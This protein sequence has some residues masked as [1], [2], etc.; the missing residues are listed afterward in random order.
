[1]AGPREWL[2]SLLAN[3]NGDIV[4]D[5]TPDSAGLNLQVEEAEF[6]E[7]RAG[8]G[9]ELALM[10]LA[11]LDQL[12]QEDLAEG[13]FCG[14]LVP[15]QSAVRLERDLA[16]ILKF[17][18]PFTG[19]FSASVTGNTRQTAFKVKLTP[20]L[21]SGERIEHYSLKG[22]ILSFSTTERFLLNPGQ[23]AAL[24]AV[25]SH[26]V[27]SSELSVEET[28]LRLVHT[29]QVARE[30]GFEAD[31]SHFDDLTIHVPPKIGLTV[32]EQDDGSLVLSPNLN[33]G[34]APEKVARGMG[35]ALTGGKSGS[36]RVDNE[37]ILLDEAAISSVKHVIERSHVP[38][39]LAKDFLE[40]PTMY[41]DSAL[42][43]LD[44][45]FSKRVKG[46]GVYTFC[47]FGSDDQKSMDWF[48]PV[49]TQN[50]EEALVE[51]L[52]SP[53][54]KKRLRQAIER[55][56]EQGAGEVV[57]EGVTLPLTDD[58]DV[59]EFVKN[60][61]IREH[62]H[63]VEGQSEFPEGLPTPDVVEAPVV[64][65]SK[66]VVVLN[67]LEGE[68]SI[69]L[70]GST[71]FQ[72]NLEN[73]A[74]SPFP[75]QEEGV[76]WI[77]SL[78][79]SSG[80]TGGLLADDM[81]LGKTYMTLVA[82]QQWML[83]QSDDEERKPSLIVAPLAL[84]EN[85]EEEVA[86]TFKTSPFKDIV[87]L[88]AG[89]DLPRYRVAG[90]GKET[91]QNVDDDTV[92]AKEE[93]RYSL[94]IGDNYKK[95]RLD[96]PARLVITTYQTLASYQFSLCRVDWNFVVFDEAQN[97]KNLNTL[98]TRAAKGLKADFKLLATGTPVENSLSDFWCLMD[99]AQPGLLGEWKDFNQQ[100]IRPIAIAEET[101]LSVVRAEIGRTLRETVGSLMLRRL[102]EETLKGLPK[103]TVYS[104]RDNQEFER[105]HFDPKLATMLSGRQLGVYDS[106]V[107]FVREN[108]DQGPAVILQG[109][110][111][112][113]AVSIHP[114]ARNTSAPDPAK[115]G[116]SSV[117][118]GVVECL[119][120]EV[121]GRD[122]KVIVF[123]INKLVQ[124]RLKLWLESTFGISVDIVNGETK[125]TAKDKRVNTRK[126]IVDSFQSAPGFGVLIMSPIAAGVGLTITGANNVI[127]LERHWNP[128]K[129]AQ[130]TDRVYRIGATKDVNV[131][132]P[133][134]HHPEFDSFEVTL[135]RLL[136]RKTDLKDAVV[137]TEDVNAAD[138][139]AGFQPA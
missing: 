118:I 91:K 1:M 53:E 22:P 93:I 25:A 21:A 67:E 55:A 15:S 94:K 85:W 119:V 9:S 86:L 101:E 44:D 126:R 128:A 115:W 46:A 10:Q 83:N 76:K 2:R 26:S 40:S 23:L 41:L 127:H 120:S 5:L 116:D 108:L 11:F 62:P 64:G 63:E 4:F 69:D 95:D 98:Q 49:D 56:Q 117:K 50:V 113:R 104:G 102:K 47:D 16:D 20:S 57:Y 137:T 79:E 48:G 32:D 17:P 59:G 52:K 107:D 109:L 58:F 89:R 28:N 78:R 123:L 135:D 72:I 84:L 112:L 19:E 51:V 132:L 66:A 130:A 74:R 30:A 122:E 125:A 3:S 31:L 6:A 99:T 39:G 71:S 24:S 100:Y 82:L 29:L 68:G 27:E 103:K 61:E 65:P 110:A 88:Q 35:Q 12:E 7:L 96:Q 14:F 134:V 37:I 87:V 131:Y 139:V 81:G 45:G 92:L 36:V 97:L 90:A 75:H 18:P 33:C 38:A 77:Y 80:V 60:Y 13:I 129:E 43:D 105:I 124:V 133:I 136:N 111:E 73:L 34:V 42:I 106:A 70:P 8:R 138:I 114:D 121:R 54:D